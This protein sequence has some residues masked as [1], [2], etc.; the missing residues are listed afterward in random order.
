VGPVVGVVVA[1]AGAVL[2]ASSVLFEVPEVAPTGGVVFGGDAP[3][4]DPTWLVLGVAVVLVAAWVVLAGKRVAGVVAAVAGVLGAGLLLAGDLASGVSGG[5]ASALL[6][7]AVLV[8]VAGAVRR[9]P[10]GARWA[11]VAGVV[12]LVVAGAGVLVVPRVARSVV[13]DAAG[14]RPLPAG[15]V[16]DRPTGAPWRWTAD[17][18]VVAAVAAGPGVVVGTR[19]GAVALV[20]RGGEQGWRYRR[21]GAEV[22]AL[23]ATPDGSLVV[24]VFG[25]SGPFE[26]DETLWVVLD[27][28]TGAVVRQ[29]AGPAADATYPRPTGTAAVTWERTDLPLG[30]VEYTAAAV[31]LRTGR[32]LWTWRAPDG[33]RSPHPVIEAAADTV[34]VPLTC[35]QE[36]GLAGLDDRDGHERWRS[37]TRTGQP[38]RLVADVGHDGDVV[39]LTAHFTTGSL[40]HSRDGRPIAEPDPR[41]RFRASAG[42][43]PVGQVRDTDNAVTATFVADPATGA[44]R[45][46]AEVPCARQLTVA[47][48]RTTLLRLCSTDTGADLVWQELDRGAGHRAPVP[49]WRP[50]NRS[51]PGDHRS[52]FDDDGILPAPG[53]LAVV[54]LGSATVVGFPG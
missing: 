31:E 1:V 6:L 52:A 40:I 30:Q 19:T 45:A 14:A 41:P 42:P 2:A 39:S 27:P 37:L 43:L 23:R 4:A 28:V 29:W 9:R 34:L 35:G 46:V 38:E 5:G 16:A 7:G 20:A 10:S 47:G 8:L 53:F 26:R 11:A 48:T 22:T 13:V 21:A 54:Q 33:C 44:V 3:R 50:P 12:V 25:G 15:D 17:G 49:G 24:A 32:R 36:H 18:P 51:V